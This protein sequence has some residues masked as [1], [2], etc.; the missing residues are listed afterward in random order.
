MS[1]IDYRHPLVYQTVVF[2][3]LQQLH[4]AISVVHENGRTFIW[5]SV[6]LAV[7][8]LL[9]GCLLLAQKAAGA[10]PSAL[11][12]IDVADYIDRRNR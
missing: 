11:Q 12:L 7:L 6:Y 5:K 1:F 9:Q 3:R 8:T 4:K 10:S 2:E